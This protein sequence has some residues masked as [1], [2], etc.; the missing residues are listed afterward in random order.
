VEID[1]GNI[2]I[3]RCARKQSDE[4]VRSVRFQEIIF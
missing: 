4:A 2:L 3:P 1:C